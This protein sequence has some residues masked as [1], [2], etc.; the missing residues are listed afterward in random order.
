MNWIIYSKSESLFLSEDESYSLLES[1]LSFPVKL[2]SPRSIALLAW[3]LL[4]VR[5]LYFDIVFKHAHCKSL[6]EVFLISAH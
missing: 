4:Y 3:L 2:L 1:H 5:P 6:L